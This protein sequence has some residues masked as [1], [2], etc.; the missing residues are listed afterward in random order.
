MP[1]LRKTEAQRR[2]ERFGERYR[3]GKALIGATEE[4]IGRLLGIKR[5]TLLEK[6]NNPGKFSVDQLVTIGKAFGWS[7]EDYLAI[8]RPDRQR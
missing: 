1:K 4:Q 6:R 3:V 2:A 7:D 8:I 5:P